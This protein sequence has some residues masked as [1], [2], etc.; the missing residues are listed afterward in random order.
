MP[1]ANIVFAIA[2]LTEEQSA[3]DLYSA[4]VPAGR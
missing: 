3:A 2:G 1:A 4:A